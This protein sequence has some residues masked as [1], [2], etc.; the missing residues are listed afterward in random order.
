MADRPPITGSTRLAA[1]IGHPVRHSLSPRIHNAGFAAAGLDWSYVAFDVAPAD[2]ARVVEAMRTLG[3]GG[4]SVTMPHKAAV[5]VAADDRTPAADRLGV[6]N[7]L[8]WRGDRIVADSTDGD[9]FVAA[10]ERMVGRSP[11]GHSFGHRRRRRGG[12]FHHR[13]AWAPRGRPCCGRQPLRGAVG[14]GIGAGRH[15]ASGAPKPT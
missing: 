3:L 6:A 10:Y 4:L 13:G 5:A 9:G 7:C 2:G 11:A 1:V 12:P 15:G 8:F 14:S